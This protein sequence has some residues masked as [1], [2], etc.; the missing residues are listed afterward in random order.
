MNS[1]KRTTQLCFLVVISGLFIVA[2]HQYYYYDFYADITGSI[3]YL[4]GHHDQNQK[5]PT[6]SSLG[7]KIQQIHS[8]HSERS[9]SL[10]DL[11]F[12]YDVSIHLSKQ[13]SSG[14]VQRL[15]WNVIMLMDSENYEA[16][17]EFEHRLKQH[18]TDVAESII[19]ENVDR[20]GGFGVELD[21][22]YHRVETTFGILNHAGLLYQY[23]SSAVSEDCTQEQNSSATC[24]PQSESRP[25]HI[26]Q[27][28]AQTK[29]QLLEALESCT[30]M[31]AY[32]YSPLKSTHVQSLVVYYSPTV[33]T[34]VVSKAQWQN[35]ISMDS[36][37][38]GRRGDVF[39][40]H[41]NDNTLFVIV[42]SDNEASSSV[43]SP[44]ASFSR[45]E[46][47]A[48]RTTSKIAGVIRKAM[49]CT[50]SDADAIEMKDVNDLFTLEVLSEAE[51][52]AMHVQLAGTSIKRI[53]RLL[54]IAA[55]FLTALVSASSARAYSPL[56]EHIISVYGELVALL[57]KRA[58]RGD[59]E[60]PWRGEEGVNASEK[61]DL[62]RVESLCT[63]ILDAMDVLLYQPKDTVFSLQNT[64]SISLSM[65]NS[66]FD[67]LEH[68]VALYAPFWVPII[69][70]LF[71]GLYGLFKTLR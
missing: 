37:V 29:S 39:T 67:E 12:P 15:Q 32:R 35:T 13:L 36:L 50:D 14:T 27:G 58:I 1:I 26:I 65:Y 43:D 59:P 20:V 24:I 38:N 22:R 33:H 9:E 68:K 3:D 17:V 42:N 10:F 21:I 25:L 48:R 40:L 60:S 46:A 11:S 57:R 45:I 8:T 30:H 7:H 41:L 56:V 69:Y 51:A 34:H 19:S 70:P 44:S 61:R 52:T 6:G 31:G 55:E 2:F 63:D 18:V 64:Q 23:V 4:I 62:V 66:L 71:V 5:Q 47:A 16:H 28:G 53:H 49:V 54:P